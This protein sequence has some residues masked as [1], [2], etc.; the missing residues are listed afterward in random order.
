M[1]KTVEFPQVHFLLFFLGGHPLLVRRRPG[2]AHDDSQLR[3]IEGW[4]L[5]GLPRVLL[6]G[7]LAHAHCN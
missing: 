4:V 1:T 6:L 2:G 5:L 7:D 3:V